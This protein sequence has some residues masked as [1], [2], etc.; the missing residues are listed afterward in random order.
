MVSA[1]GVQ[2]G[3]DFLGKVSMEE[4]GEKTWILQIPGI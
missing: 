3:N 4:V 1:V 2:D